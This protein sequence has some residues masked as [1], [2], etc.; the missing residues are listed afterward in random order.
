MGKKSKTKSKK[1]K[2][3]NASPLPPAPPGIDKDELIRSSDECPG[4]FRWSETKKWPK[5]PPYPHSPVEYCKGWGPYLKSRGGNGLLSLAKSDP[6]ILDCLSFPVTLIQA[7]K[8][9][10]LTPGP[11][12]RVV[13]LGASR[14]AE[15]RT[16]RSTQYWDE[17]AHCFEGSKITLSFVGPE[18]S[19]TGPIAGSGLVEAS[20]FRGNLRDFRAAHPGLAS[21]THSTIFVVFNGGFGNFVESHNFSLLWSWLPDLMLLTKIRAPLVF[22][23]ANDYADVRGE[24]EVMHKL[25]G[26]RFIAAPEKNAAGFATTLLG[27]GVAPEDATG[28]SRGNSFWYSVCGY[29]AERRVHIDDAATPAEK[30]REVMRCFAAPGTKSISVAPADEGPMLWGQAAHDQNPAHEFTQTGTDLVL[31]VHTEELQSMND[32]YLEVAD[33]RIFLKWQ[34]A[35]EPSSGS[36]AV[37][38]TLDVMLPRKVL[39]NEVRASFSRQKQKLKVRMPIS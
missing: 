18:I 10:G 28:W 2:E 27:E 37:Y 32:A 39:P 1:G 25:L 3:D 26:A 35:G 16:A 21:D 31:S 8:R 6:S 14:R 4:T 7:L 38:A 30:T 36:A 24:M 29:D 33:D 12:M 19:A 5:L 13:I 9:L 17:V 20:S 22:T 11:V 15:E 34:K 23:C